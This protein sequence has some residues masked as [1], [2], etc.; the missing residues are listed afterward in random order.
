MC[1][2]AGVVYTDRREV[3]RDLV[4]GM[5]D[6][7]K[8]RGPD[9]DGVWTDAGVGLGHCRLSIIDL[10]KAGHQPMNGTD[11]RTWIT[12]NG[13]VYNHAELRSVLE[14]TGSRFRSKTDTEVLL[15][16]WESHGPAMLERLNGMFAFGIWDHSRQELFL[17]RDRVGIKPL[18]YAVL[19]GGLAFA[20]EIKAL[21]CVPSIGG[22]IDLESLGYYFCMGYTPRDYTPFTGIRRLLP[23]HFLRFRLAEKHPTPEIQRYWTLND[24][25]S[26]G[27]THTFA[28]SVDLIRDRIHTSVRYRKMSDA[29]LGAFLSGGLDSSLVVGA[30]SECIE[31]ALDTFTIGFQEHGS[32]ER[33]Y[34]RAVADHVHTRHHEQV[35]ELSAISSVDQICPNLDDFLADNSIIPTYYVSKMARSAVKVTLSGDG[36]DEG[37]GGYTRYTRMERSRIFDR[38][39]TLLRR[40]AFGYLARSWPS[41]R[42][43]KGMLQR[44]ALSFIDRYLDMVSV[45]PSDEWRGILRPEIQHALEDFRPYDL[46]RKIYQEAP[47]DPVERLLRLDVETYLPDDI[48]Q[49]V[50]RASMQVSLETR[51]PLLD[52]ELLE[53]AFRV[54]LEQRMMGGRRKELLRAAARKWLPESVLTERK[55][56]FVM[57]I[58][59]WFRKE[60]GDRFEIEVRSTGWQAREF[61]DPARVLDILHAHRTGSRDFGRRLWAILMFS[62]WC[63]Y[64]ATG[65]DR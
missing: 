2:I 25:S 16:L 45:F 11:E 24:Y 46:Y 60:L 12:Y 59:L 32:D 42:L 33:A 58:G 28:D 23:G 9:D 6:R 31:T 36:G 27:S 4:A 10:S 55:Q 13:E 35:V 26:E 40:P 44:A 61:V 57:P 41:N 14:T 51:V 21:L 62:E 30:L 47:G 15:H 43:G 1:G 38:I 18:Y 52:H 48:L 29:P 37:F 34:A 50:D 49:K 5:I 64:Y 65:H 20:S 63:K 7:I 53:A 22:Q 17:A 19:P 8:H 56:G 39:P 54:P 3:S